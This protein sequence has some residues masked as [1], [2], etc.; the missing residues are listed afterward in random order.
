MDGRR[1]LDAL[2]QY[3]RNDSDRAVGV[4]REE[5][6]QQDKADVERILAEHHQQYGHGRHYV[7]R[8]GAQGRGSL[9]GHGTSGGHVARYAR[10]DWS[11]QWGVT[12]TK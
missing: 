7:A 3:A 8:T 10:T 4:A 11:I 6:R 12:A 9:V 5:W 2:L 1:S